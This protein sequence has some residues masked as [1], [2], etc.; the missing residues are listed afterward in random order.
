MSVF[1]LRVVPKLGRPHNGCN[2]RKTFTTGEVGLSHFENMQICTTFLRFETSN[3]KAQ[4]FVGL[5][6]INP[7]LNLWLGQNVQ[8]AHAPGKLTT[9]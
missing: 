3:P 6:R 5:K 2:H 7:I 8:T 4:Y 9:G 1:R